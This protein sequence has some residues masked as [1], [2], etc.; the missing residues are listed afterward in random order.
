VKSIDE[1]DQTL[2]EA[3]RFDDTRPNEDQRGSLQKSL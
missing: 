1:T 2:G 3:V